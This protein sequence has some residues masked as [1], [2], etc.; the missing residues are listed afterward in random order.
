[1]EPTRR[2]FIVGLGAA[3]TLT[4]C[5]KT[6]LTTTTVT[7]EASP[8]IAIAGAATTAEGTILIDPLGSYEIIDSATGAEVRVTVNGG[9]RR[10]IANGL[11]DHET[12]EFP[13]AQNPNSISAQMY[14]IELPAS[15]IT[16]DQPSGYSLPQPFGIALNGVPFDPLAAEF[17]QR[18]FDSGW[19]YE[20]LG[21]GIQLGLDGQNAHV[22]P[23][24]AYHYHGIPADVVSSWSSTTHGPLIGWGGDGFPIYVRT[25]YRDESDASSPIINLQSS[26]QIRSGTRP[27]GP[28]GA[29]DGTYIQDYEYVEG[30][31][32][33]DESNGRFGV[34]PEFP[35]G[36][37]HYILTDVFPT[38][39]RSFRGDLAASFTKSGRP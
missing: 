20:A 6:A 39:P 19:Q 11:P 16:N 34:T 7:G 18:D 15:P 37:Y 30:S 28:G 12:G 14:D 4:A 35:N 26:Y 5:G 8:T 21:G 25:G 24:G 38:I 33:L 13:N 23:T 27:D 1:M 2:Q 10:M 32:D 31:G 17:Y 29:Y 22:Q 9:V 3:L 36:T